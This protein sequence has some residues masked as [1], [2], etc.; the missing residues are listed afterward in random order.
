MTPKRV[1]GGAAVVVRVRAEEEEEKYDS[2]DAEVEEEEDVGEPQPPEEVSLALG[3]GVEKRLVHNVQD[4]EATGPRRARVYVDDPPEAVA[5]ALEATGGGASEEAVHAVALASAAVAAAGGARPMGANAQAFVRYL[6]IVGHQFI[7]CTLTGA[8]ALI[9]IDTPARVSM[10][11]FI[12]MMPVLYTLL[13]AWYAAGGMGMAFKPL[14]RTAWTI[15][16]MY[17]TPC[18]C[19]VIFLALKGALDAEDAKAAFRQYL[20]GG[21]IGIA[22]FIMSRWLAAGA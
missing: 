2:S 11:L 17:G 6:E 12:P 19:G 5:D 7:T 13:V 16:L 9:L 4:V 15:Y 22:L 1:R 20:C 3:P 8:L 10:V 18:V 21:M 14:L